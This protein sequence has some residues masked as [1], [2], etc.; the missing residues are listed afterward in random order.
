MMKLIISASLRFRY[1]VLALSLVLTWFGLAQ[2]RDVPVDV[3]PEFAPP[4]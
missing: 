1:L 2:L 4:R 3:F